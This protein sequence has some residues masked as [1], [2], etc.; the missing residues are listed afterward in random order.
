ME[1]SAPEGPIKDKYS[2]FV[3]LGEPNY[4]RQYREV[5]TMGDVGT[6]KTSAAMDA[7]I[8][9]AVNYPGSKNLVAREFKSYLMSSTWNTFTSR[10]KDLIKSK[11]F[12]WIDS[13]DMFRARNGSTIHFL[14]LDRAEDRMF[15]EEWFRAAIDQGE[16]IKE[17]RIDMLHSRMRQK[18]HH[19]DSSI[20]ASAGTLTNTL[21]S[22]WIKLTGNWDKGR[23]YPYRRVVHGGK[24]VAPDIYTKEVTAVVGG[25]RITAHRMMIHSRIEENKSLSRD[26]LE[27]L[28]LAGELSRRVAGGKYQDE[29]GIIFL[30]YQEEAQLSKVEYVDANIVVG[31]DWG[32]SHPTVAIFGAVGPDGRCEIIREYL[33]T[34]DTVAGYAWDIGRI[35]VELDRFGAKAFYVYGDRSMWR[36]DDDSSIANRFAEE[37]SKLPVEVMF[38]PAVKNVS[39]SID[40]GINDIK[41]GLRYGTLR[42][43]VDSA[44]NVARML[45]SITYEDVRKD[46]SPLVDIF[47]ATRY[48]VMNATLARPEEEKE[49]QAPRGW[50]W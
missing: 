37:F 47:D 30:E 18:V 14:G 43:A 21:G 5:W 7:I 41:E 45:Q 46:R 40:R 42:V 23:G 49:E 3:M 15:G 35:M 2:L 1:L 36:R 27:H 8:L 9:S 34:D 50:A 17:P 4:P 33:K 48:L 29:E 12:E 25:E 24:L 28:V 38:A 26:Y 10:A 19:R 22:N 44:P 13:K 39:G 6:A 16:R 32:Q 20:L 31:L 11:F